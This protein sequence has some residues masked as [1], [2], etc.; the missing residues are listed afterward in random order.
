MKEFLITIIGLIL[1][2]FFIY[3]NHKYT[4]G[5]KAD[6]EEVQYG[7]VVFHADWCGPCQSMKAE[8]WANPEFQKYIKD[9]DM[10]FFYV[11][12]D[13]NQEAVKKYKVSSLPSGFYIQFLKSDE[14]KGGIIRK[15]VGYK[16]KQEVFDFLEGKK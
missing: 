5:K 11:N 16:T 2:S 15:F 9:H 10:R 1:V 13:Q 12:A 8:T 14:T 4:Y 3:A 6:A 7:L